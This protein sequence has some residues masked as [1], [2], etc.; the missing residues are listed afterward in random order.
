MIIM[1]LLFVCAECGEETTLISTTAQ[2]PEKLATPIGCLL[3]AGKEV[4]HAFGK[5]QL[6]PRC[7]ADQAG[8][9]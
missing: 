8:P 2:V 5:A 6:C 1:N 7:G 3:V 9:G 4:E